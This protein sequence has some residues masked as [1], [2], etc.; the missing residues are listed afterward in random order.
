MA[1][2]FWE[3]IG[4]N[5]AVLAL[6]VARLADAIGNS[7]LFILIPLYVAALPSQV[8][9]FPIPVLVGILISLYGIVNSMA[10]PLMGALSDKLGK[11]KRMIQLGLLIMGLGTLGF[12]LA[13]RFIDLIVLRICQGIGVAITI[14]ASMG[15][16]ASITK[17]ET[18][19]GSMGIYSMLR[20]V[21]FAGGPVI[22][23]FL[24][25]HFG[26]NSAF[27]SGAAFLFLALILVQIWVNDVTPNNQN[28][29]AK[30]KLFDKSLVSPGIFSAAAATFIMALAFSMVTT[31][32]NEF[33]AKLGINA[34]G[35]S[36]AFSSL[37]IGRLI[38]QIPLGRLSDHIGRKP[39]ILGGLLLLAPA[40]ALLGEA[41]SMLQLTLLRVFQGIAAAGIAAP[42]FA[43]VGDLAK[44]GG[45]ARQMS[46]ITM[47]FGLGMAIG[48]LIA[49]VLAIIFFELPFLAGAALSLIGVWIVF[50]FMPE[51]VHGRKAIFHKQ[52]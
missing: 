30:F 45:E 21:G 18:R 2:G 8:L 38:L 15:L 52:S 39:L 20:M 26:F 16:M 13:S 44:A 46:V 50:K 51:T 31:L 9:H 11:R 22:G 43:I 17:K 12:V 29:Q 49:G 40:T 36:I 14:P 48:P 6:S 41:T 47:G 23:G 27:Y 35:F 32:E 5:R 7:I 1:P 42:A 34:L 3:S 25:V 4:A 10:Q 37:M 19:G 24:Q 28:Q 33:N